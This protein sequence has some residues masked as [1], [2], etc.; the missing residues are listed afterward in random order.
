MELT[1]SFLM[2]A[3]VSAVLGLIILLAA[4]HSLDG[5][6]NS[7]SLYAWITVSS[8]AG[9]WIVLTLSKF[10]EGSE[11][12]DIR[13][14][15][16][17][18]VAGLVV[19]VLCF[20]ASELLMLQLSRGEMFNVLEMPNSM[21]PASMYFT[22]GAPR[23]TAFLAFFATMFAILR[24]WRPVDPLRRTRFSLWATIVCVF[25]GLLIPWQ[26]P[27]GFLLIATI[28]VASQISAPYMNK[29][30]RSRIRRELLEA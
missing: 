7:L 8:I 21:I 23:V 26:V 15:F 14:R 16:A 17:M 27:W 9:S 11:G 24:W 25:W 4:G 5:S 2:S 1:G 3:I 30:E 10:W 29:S 6:V 13:R 22:D 19:G 18:M 28:S 12:D 20:A